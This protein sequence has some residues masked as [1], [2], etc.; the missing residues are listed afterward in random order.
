MNWAQYVLKIYIK[1]LIIFMLIGDVHLV[2]H[3]LKL[4]FV[5]LSIKNMPSD[6]EK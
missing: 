1:D 2:G 6:K 5:L 3:K 4:M